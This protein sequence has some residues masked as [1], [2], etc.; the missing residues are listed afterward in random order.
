MLRSPTRWGSPAGCRSRCPWWWSTSWPARRRV[1]DRADRG[2]LTGG[3][4]PPRPR[5]P[6][7]AW[8]CSPWPSAPPSCAPGS[9]LD[10]ISSRTVAYGLLTLL[11]AGGDAGIAL[12][13]GRLLGRESSL[14]VAA[15]IL[16]VVAL[17]QPARGGFKRWSTGASTAAATTPPAPWRGSDPS[18]RPARP[19]HPDRRAAGRGQPDRAANPDVAL[20]ATARSPGPSVAATTAPISTTTC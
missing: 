20:A 11:L 12:G 14:V 7:C 16:A 4:V 9:Y 8:S 17:F 3:A 18:P 10:Q 1:A 19:D 2:G 5:A 15:A 6:G 13:L